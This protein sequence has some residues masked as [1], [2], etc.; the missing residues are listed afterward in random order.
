MAS[1]YRFC[2]MVFGAMPLPRAVSNA[3]PSTSLDGSGRRLVVPPLIIRSSRPTDESVRSWPCLEERQQLLEEQRDPLGLVG[4]MPVIVISLPRTRISAVERRLDEL[5]EARRAG[6][7]GPPWAGDPGRGSSLG[8]WRSPSTRLSGPAPFPPV[9]SDGPP[10]DG[11][12]GDSSPS[13]TRSLNQ[14]ATPSGG[15]PGDGSAGGTPS[16]RNPDRRS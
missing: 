16:G 12:P 13:R 2:P 15:H 5:Q 10:L 9:S 7:G 1:T 6:R 3:S 4:A 14:G 8:W 11:L